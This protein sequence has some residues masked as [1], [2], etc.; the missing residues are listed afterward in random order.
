MAVTLRRT[1]ARTGSSTPSDAF[2]SP[3]VPPQRP[4]FAGPEHA[5]RGVTTRPYGLAPGRLRSRGKVLLNYRCPI[6]TA[7]V[8]I[9]IPSWSEYPTGSPVSRAMVCMAKRFTS[10]QAAGSSMQ[11][12]DRQHISQRF[13]HSRQPACA[14]SQ[15][16][17]RALSPLRSAM[18]VERI[19]GNPLRGK[20]PQEGLVGDLSRWNLMRRIP[21]PSRKLAASSSNGVDMNS[22]PRPASLVKAAKRRF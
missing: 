6:A 13:S 7:A 14:S 10:L 8:G 16:R 19:I 15:R 22:M 3:P 12:E 4:E 11:M 21:R 9:A 5:T 17:P 20:E 18:P 1:R 2:Q